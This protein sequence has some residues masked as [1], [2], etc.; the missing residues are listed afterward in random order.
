[1]AAG[2]SM[3]SLPSGTVIAF[4][5]YRLSRNPALLFADGQPVAIGARAIAL[6]RV[7]LEGDGQPV[8]IGELRKHVWPHIDVGANTVQSQIAS[9]R[10]A[11]G[12]E[13]HLIVTVRGYGYRF[14]GEQHRVPDTG[15]AREPAREHGTG[16][17]AASSF[18]P[19]SP[20]ST[21][22]AAASAGTRGPAAPA[23][24]T[25]ALLLPRGATPF[26][27]R[28]AEVSEL[29]GLVPAHRVVTLTGAPGIGK[30]RVAVEIAR[31]LA[32][33]FPHGAFVVPPSPRE[34]V[35]RLV[36]RCIAAMRLNPEPGLARSEQLRA[37]MSAR[38][39]L[40]VIDGCDALPP[41]TLAFIAALVAAPS[42]SRVVATAVHALNITSERVV[43][44]ASLQTP[45]CWHEPPPLALQRDAL[46]LLFTRLRLISDPRG[47]ERQ[48]RSPVASRIVRDAATTPRNIAAAAR[49]A[50]HAA[51]VPLALQFAAT[52]VARRIRAG[53][54]LEV[55]LIALARELDA[56]AP[57]AQAA[58]GDA[59]YCASRVATMLEL[60]T[61]GLNDDARRVFWCLGAFADTFTRDA[62]LDM[63]ASFPVEPPPRDGAEPP[64]DVTLDTCLPVLIEAGLVERLEHDGKIAFRMSKPVRMH[65]LASLQR[66][67]ETDRQGAQVVL[68]ACS[69]TA[70]REP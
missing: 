13:G 19:S 60:C 41:D 61:A 12:N 37:W 58:K 56:S 17:T 59:S 50:R 33:R 32:A 23:E 39:V 22:P 5:R 21:A 45:A 6:L 47:F 15:G 68:L 46:Q 3:P 25:C 57:P 49:I 66:A 36:A 48:R 8:A 16:R 34:Q 63:L 54:A 69:N 43:Q 42:D 65:A 30:T 14:A 2:R 31:R 11:L 29:L 64:A 28:H 35:E 20:S 52:A 67:G 7:L 26:V 40:L 62:A 55:A 44:L 18:S 70:Y 27:G 1:M 9:L 24:L 4:G 51:G 10:R 38:R 53:D